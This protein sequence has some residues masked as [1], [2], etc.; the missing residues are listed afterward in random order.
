MRSKWKYTLTNVYS[1]C[2]FYI[3]E[4]HQCDLQTEQQAKSGPKV[5][6]HPALTEICI[7][8]HFEMKEL[9]SPC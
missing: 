8:Y 4:A 9:S 5:Q 3:L 1:E 2:I 7:C 6:L